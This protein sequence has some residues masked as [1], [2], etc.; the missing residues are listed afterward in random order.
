MADWLSAVCDER[1]GSSDIAG[2]VALVV[3]E[4]GSRAGVEVVSVGVVL[5]LWGRPHSELS[6]KG[7]IVFV[8]TSDNCK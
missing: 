4:S 1:R 7:R 2:V 5:W 6:L 8:R 3:V